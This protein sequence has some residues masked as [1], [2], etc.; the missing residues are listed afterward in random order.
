MWL[1]F[2]FSVSFRDVEEMVAA[3]GVAV[4]YET[5]R[6]W[7]DKFG[8]AYADGISRRRART[9]DRWHLDEVF[10]KINGI[11]HYL[12]SLPLASG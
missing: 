1:Y 4:S 6:C 5:I 12:Y 10:L 11:T 9:G 3:R 2:R 8:K 7:C